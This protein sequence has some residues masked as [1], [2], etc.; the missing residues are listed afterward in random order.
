MRAIG[1]PR[2]ADI[3]AR[4]IDSAEARDASLFFRN[5]DA[6]ADLLRHSSEPIMPEILSRLL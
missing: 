2:C 6:L 4:S 5:D 1:D 3:R